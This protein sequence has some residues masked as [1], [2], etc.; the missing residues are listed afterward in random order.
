MVKGIVDWVD[1]WSVA[2]PLGRAIYS[3]TKN[4]DPFLL[5]GAGSPLISTRRPVKACPYVS[6]K[7]KVVGE[8]AD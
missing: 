4:S 5:L 8:P 7:I 2:V 6:H 3:P 1:S